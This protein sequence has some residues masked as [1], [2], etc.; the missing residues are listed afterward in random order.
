M[1]AVLF[2]INVLLCI[3]TFLA[4]SMLQNHF[5]K[6]HR[7]M[8]IYL[9]SK[10]YKPSSEIS[11]LTKVLKRYQELS[12]GR[13]GQATIVPHIDVEVML[14][15]ALYEEKIG[16]FSYLGVQTMAVK[17]KVI[18]WA[19]VVVQIGLEIAGGEPGRSLNNFIFIVAS[20]LICML[21]TLYAIIKSVPEHREQL[22][23]KVHDYIVNTYPSDLLGRSKQQEIKELMERIQKLEDELENYHQHPEVK[24]DKLNG[25][26]IMHLLKE[27]DLHV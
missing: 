1:I 18:M 26:E 27:I 3:T 13:E 11:F 20:T 17:G 4:T 6:I 22:I 21:V 15:K 19:I 23:V 9:D 10:A 2:G 12:H 24:E 16:K 25:K 14:H 7:S 5:K 8:T